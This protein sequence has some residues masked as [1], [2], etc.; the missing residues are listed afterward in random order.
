MASNRLKPVFETSPKLS[1]NPQ[2]TIIYNTKIVSV[3]TPSGNANIRL[4]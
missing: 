2:K 4:T 1:T 3:A